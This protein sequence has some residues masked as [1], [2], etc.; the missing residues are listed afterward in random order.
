MQKRLILDGPNLEITLN[1]LCE[2]LLETHGQ[3][4]DSVILGLQPRGIYVA[5]RI[6]TRLQFLVTNPIHLGHL[7][8]T[9][10]RDD[11]RRRETPKRANETR[12]TFIIEN[13]MVVLVDDV[14]YTGRSVRAAMDAMIAFGRPS[15]VELLVLID[16][17]FSRQLPI[18]PNY[19][20]KRV[21]TMHSQVVE[22]EWQEQGY[23]KDKIWLID[24]E[25]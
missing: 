4:E 5:E 24:K 19:V 17:K 18:E 6:K 14:L 2:Q 21:N 7:D 3:F 9:F 16:R 15:K 12:V 11:F 23:K 1:R 25:D 22:V 10:Y 20:G 13:K 8:I